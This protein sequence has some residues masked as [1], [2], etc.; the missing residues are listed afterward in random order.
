MEPPADASALLPQASAG[1]PLPAPTHATPTALTGGTGFNDAPRLTGG[2]TYQDTLATGQ[3]KFYRVPQQWGQRLSYLVSEVGP[4]QPSL[5]IVGSPV[6]VNLFNPVRSDVTAIS[7]TTGLWFA[8]EPYESFSGSTPYPVRY[9][10]RGGVEQRGFSLD[11][12]YYLRVNANRNDDEPSSTTFLI[13]VVVSGEVEPGPIYQAAGAGS[14][15]SSPSST[16]AASSSV[17]A[18]TTA[19]SSA[20]APTD[21]NPTDVTAAPTGQATPINDSGV[22]GWIWVVVAVLAAGA[23][24]IV[25]FLRAR[26]RAGPSQGTDWN[27]QPGGRH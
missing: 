17:P 11:G 25:L 22:P 15:T 5:G 16:P 10:N 19:S 18:A 21:T 1:D 24:A 9:T 13:T 26:R 3:S 6:R 14:V 8:D 4:A 7:G 23:L 20:T 27:G 12:D 2:G